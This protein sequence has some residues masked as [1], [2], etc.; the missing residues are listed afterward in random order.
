MFLFASC[1]L[2]SAAQVC[3]AFGIFVWGRYQSGTTKMSS[4]NKEASSSS[5]A[6]AGG[7]SSS[8]RK[9]SS[10]RVPDNA[11]AKVRVKPAKKAR[12]AEQAPMKICVRKFTN[13]ASDYV[14]MA[15]PGS[16][17]WSVIIAHEA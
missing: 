7:G 1:F 2:L 12:R 5:A 13:Q 10:L 14:R 17:L 3:A 9:R 11:E 8:P 15:P 6:K 4:S 16:K